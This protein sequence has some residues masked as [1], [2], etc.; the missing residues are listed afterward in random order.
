LGRKVH[1]TGFRLKVTKTWD[2]RWFA[3]GEQYVEHLQEDLAIRGAGDLIGTAQS[4][5]PRFRIADLESQTSLMALAQ[6]DARTLLAQDPTLEGPRGQ[7][8]RVLLW[9]LERDKAI[10]LISVA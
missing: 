7:N 3:E 9:L 1:P 2:V 6:S 8:T 10:R 4:G 5:L